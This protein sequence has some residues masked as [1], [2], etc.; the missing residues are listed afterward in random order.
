MIN[1]NL[2]N[3]GLRGVLKPSEFM[4]LYVIANNLGKKTYKEIYYDMIADL[5]GLS[6]RQI[7]RIVDSLEEKGF[8]I[9][10][11]TQQTKNKRKSFYSLNLDILNDKND[12]FDDTNVT[13]QITI[14]N[15]KEYKDYIDNKESWIEDALLEMDSV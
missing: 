13:S 6:T 11:T 15:N 12:E 1:L 3:R 4:T 7:K 14:K 2:L 5:V 8:I 10:K 9:K